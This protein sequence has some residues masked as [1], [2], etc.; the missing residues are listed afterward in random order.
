MLGRAIFFND[1]GDGTLVASNGR[2]TSET[3]PGG[4]QGE[5]G[6]EEK[7]SDVQAN[8]QPEILLHR[9]TAAA[10]DSS[11]WLIDEGSGWRRRRP[12]SQRPSTKERAGEG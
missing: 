1:D 6:S 12:A 10:P 2:S 3:T 9:P 5:L 7:S 8:L 4:K 11:K